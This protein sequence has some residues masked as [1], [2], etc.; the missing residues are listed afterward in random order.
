MKNLGRMNY[1]TQKKEGT[2]SLSL[3]LSAYFRSTGREE[4]A[5]ARSSNRSPLVF[6]N[7]RAPRTVWFSSDNS[8]WRCKFFR[9]RRV[10]ETG[11][12]LP[13]YSSG[14]HLR[15][16]FPSKKKN[17]LFECFQL[18]RVFLFFF[19]FVGLS[20]LGLRLDRY[21]SGFTCLEVFGSIVRS[22]MYDLFC[23]IRITSKWM[24]RNNFS[25]II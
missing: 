11:R 6:F 4:R 12:V 17:F 7:G 14:R 5:P 23:L 13:S 9:K 22:K 25:F 21:L 8:K 10:D 19:F 15:A 3:S 16:I 2:E 18:V 24:R 1:S 20:C